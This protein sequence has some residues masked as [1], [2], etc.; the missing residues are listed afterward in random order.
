MRQCPNIMWFD[1]DMTALLPDEI[2][3][4]GISPFISLAWLRA[5]AEWFLDEG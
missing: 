5:V 1:L 4:F 3:E 2:A